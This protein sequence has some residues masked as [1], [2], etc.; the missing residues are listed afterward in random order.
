[1]TAKGKHNTINKR[2]LSYIKKNECRFSVNKTLTE[3]EMEKR[4]IRIK[5]KTI[6]S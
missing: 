6:I 5:Q 2:F 4:D 1:M 3:R